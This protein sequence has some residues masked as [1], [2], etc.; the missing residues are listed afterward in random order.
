MPYH[1][2]QGYGLLKCAGHGSVAFLNVFVDI[3]FCICRTLADS[4]CQI[5]V[6]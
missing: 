1:G 6:A 4:I 3:D 5:L 2:D